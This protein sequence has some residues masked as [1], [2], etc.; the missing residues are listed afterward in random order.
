M[1]F[2]G[3]RLFVGGQGRGLLGKNGLLQACGGVAI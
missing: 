3:V 2:T 1:L